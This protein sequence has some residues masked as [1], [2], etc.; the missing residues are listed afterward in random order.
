MLGMHM[1]LVQTDRSG[2]KGGRVLETGGSWSIAVGILLAIGCTKPDQDSARSVASGPLAPELAWR[3]SSE[4]L[5]AAPVSLTASDGSGL[6]LVSLEARTVI[7]DPLAFTELHLVFHNPEPRR[8]EGRFEIALPPSAAISRFAMRVGGA[9]QE[10]E[11]VEKRHAQQTYEEFL[12]RKQDPALLEKAAG[13]QF[14]ARV[15]PIEASADKELIVAYSEELTRRDQP[16][17]LLLRGLPALATLKV[18]VL[19]GSSSESGLESSA[20]RPGVL[21]RLS[22]EKHGEM[23][24]ADLEVRLPSSSPFALR[25][26]NL[27]VA[28]VRPKLD[29][30]DQNIEGLSVL[31]DTSASRALGF[32]AQ[33]ERFANLLSALVRRQGKDFDLL[34]LAFDQ[35]TEEIYRGPASGFSLREKGRLLARGALGA[36]DLQQALA[37]LA[38]QHSDRGRALVITDGMITA[39]LSDTTRLKEAVAQLS[40]HGLHRLDVLAEGGI[41]DTDTAFALS[42]AGLASAGLV[43][44]ASTDSEGLAGKLLKATRDRVEVHVTGASWVYPEVLEGVQSGDERLVFAELARDTPVQIELSGAGTHALEARQA[45]EPLLRRAWARAK[46]AALTQTLRGRGHASADEQKGLEAQIVALSVAQ[47][48]LSDFTALLVLETDWDYQRFGI[49]QNAL[50]SIL[51]IGKEGIELQERQQ[52]GL[53]RDDAFGE[54]KGRQEIA[55]PEAEMAAAADDSPAGK[56]TSLERAG[57]EP[58][59][60][61]ANQAELREPSAPPPAKAT[62]RSGAAPLDARGSVRERSNGPAPAP[63]PAMAKAAAPPTS[64]PESAASRDLGAPATEGD[65][66]LGMQGL[67]TGGGGGALGPVT[68]ALEARVVVAL[69]AVQGLP[70]ALVTPVLRG[71]FAARVRACYARASERAGTTERLA[72]ALSVS[73]KGSVSDVYVSSGNLADAQARACIVTAARQLRFPKPEAGSAAVQAGLELSLVAAARPNP[74]A[75]EIARPARPR[76]S[77]GV[78]TPNIDDA[79][80]G[81]LASVFQALKAGDTVAAL[82]QASVARERDPGDVVALIALGEALEAQHD[83]S[84]AA[85][86]YGSLI[87]LFPGRADLRRMAGERLERL[88]EA[89]LVLAIDS[90]RKAVE[91]RPDHPS[92]HRLLAYALL[93]H[94][95]GKG[96]FAALE[97]ALERGFALD[98]F[99]AAERILLEDLALAGAAWLR[100]EPQAQSAIATA[101]SRR[102]TSVDAKPSLRF[103]LNWETD[104]NDVDFHIYDGRGGHAYYMRPRL[105]SG[106]ALY[107]DITSGYGPECFTIPG[108]P[109]A[110]PYVL[111]A[112]YY[113]RGPMG[114]GMGKLQVVEHDGSGSLRFA[115]HPFMIMKDKAFV[116]LGRVAGPL[117]I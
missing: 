103:V 95:D 102:G 19:L 30:P 36:S 68:P 52:P 49:A 91:L 31:F 22:L 84:R 77:P 110:Y 115:E 56:Q 64:A 11:V 20:T 94:G 17:R 32:S 99:E 28:R 75:P 34:V 76:A 55:A 80:D 6:Q 100:A 2:S 4:P 40:A 116:E 27:V 1:Q 51:T 62:A 112:H 37:Q 10:G 73:D 69:H 90:Y 78:P 26:D 60:Q 5:P 44:D 104:A 47:R 101:L 16:Y 70:N 39:G 35:D 12:H 9:F 21:G 79:Y 93:K 3:E 106:G 89:G 15:F 38:S 18:Q 96:A 29:L 48:V 66:A 97:Q 88:P 53:A 45:P 105:A 33:I 14:S 108:R 25:S 109:R 98:R 86:A 113:A 8:R 65:R 61:P 46:I 7:E 41:Q 107:A 67:G 42:H 59:Q 13:N 117:A 72:L 82:R 57:G 71:A 111:Q 58:D 24:K 54:R 92:A 43:L 83:T 81:V 74:Q 50:T 63:A 23:P 85:R 87:D 114:Y